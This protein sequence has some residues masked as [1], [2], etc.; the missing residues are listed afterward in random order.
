MEIIDNLKEVK[1]EIDKATEK[2]RILL[3]PAFDAVFERYP[4]VQ[5]IRWTQYT[6]YFNDGE[7]CEFGVH[8]I[9]FTLKNYDE[10]SGEEVE[11][12]DNWYNSWSLPK[13]SSRQWY[14]DNATKYV[15]T[16]TA[17]YYNS[18]LALLDDPKLSTLLEIDSVLK[19][20]QSYIPENVFQSLGEGM[21]IVTRKGIEV[22]E[23]DHE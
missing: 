22:E 1:Q 12:G 23:Y 9:E 11:A 10:V 15:N 7:P 13:E 20:I 16:T 8:D 14:K 18:Q 21:V 17:D 5:A 3:K 6:P 4:E 19:T 2:L